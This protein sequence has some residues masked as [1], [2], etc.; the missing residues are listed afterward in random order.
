MLNVSSAWTGCALV[1]VMPIVSA[2]VILYSDVNTLKFT[3]AETKEVAALQL[4]FTEQMTRNT[5]AI[6]NLNETLRDWKEV[7]Y[8]QQERSNRGRDREV[9]R[10]DNEMP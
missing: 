5:A 6:E 1:V 8:E 4:K 10:T 9:A 2:L 7:T 3:K